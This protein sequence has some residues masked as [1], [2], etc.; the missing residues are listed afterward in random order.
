MN[1]A[2]SLEVS[3]DVYEQTKGV[4]LQNGSKLWEH[5]VGS[6]V[7]MYSDG[8]L[9]ASTS[10][11]DYLPLNK[12]LSRQQ[13]AAF[14][15]MFKR[16]LLMQFRKNDSLYLLKIKFDKISREKNY[17]VWNRMK[18]G[19]EFYVMDL[20]S[21][22]WQMAYKLGYISKTIFLKYLDDDKYKEA[23]RYCISFLGRSNYMLYHDGRKI[24]KVVCNVDCLVSVYDNIRNSLYKAINDAKERVEDWLDYNIDAVSVMQKDVHIIAQAF[25]EMNLLYKI[26]KCIKTDEFEYMNDFGVLRKF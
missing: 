1:N 11:G 13:F 15:G 19:D 10:Q 5:A 22:Y 21:A 14:L 12:N 16:N 17:D 23:K 3:Q 20:N 4:V 8:V 7:N 18:I 25:D 9:C 6:R 24:N 2:N 26:K